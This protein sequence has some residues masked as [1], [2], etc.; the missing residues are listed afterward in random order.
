MY[1]Y[2]EYLEK[3]TWGHSYPEYARALCKEANVER[4]VLFHHLPDAADDY[5]D[6]LAEKWS[7]AN[8]PSVSIA[9]EGASVVVR[10]P[11]SVDT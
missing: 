1:D 8:N 11:A 6:Q 4:L 10:E 3:M 7:S 5:L 9:R 2:S